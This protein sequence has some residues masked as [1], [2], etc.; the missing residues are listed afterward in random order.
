M[1]Y[2]GAAALCAVSVL[3]IAFAVSAGS[4]E[5]LLLGLSGVAAAVGIAVH[6]HQALR[7]ACA[8][9]LLANALMI[10]LHVASSGFSLFA[11]ALALLSL[12]AGVGILARQQWVQIPTVITAVVT[13]GGWVA[14]ALTAAI[15]HRW[16]E[17]DL[18][19]GLISVMP[20]LLLAAIWVWCPFAVARIST[21]RATTV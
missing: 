21:P 20:G 11:L 7:Y 3:F 15:A 14:A 10:G 17:T 19:S 4:F 1:H 6:R 12:G 13:L 5:S 2:V 9:I 18:G 16:P 8:T